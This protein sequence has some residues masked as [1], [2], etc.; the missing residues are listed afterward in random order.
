[1]IGLVIVGLL[2]VAGVIAWFVGPDTRDPDFGL[3]RRDPSA[4][5]PDRGAARFP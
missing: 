3:H 5:R 1:M 2:T 4:P